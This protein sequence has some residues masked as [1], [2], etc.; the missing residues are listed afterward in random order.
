M[1]KLSQADRRKGVRKLLKG[2]SKRTA[3]LR[4]Y[5]RRRGKREGWL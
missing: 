2:K 1:A 3:G 5:W 4:K